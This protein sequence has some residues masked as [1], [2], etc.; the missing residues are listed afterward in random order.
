MNEFLDSL[1]RK[2]LI[3]SFVSW[4][5]NFSPV[6]AFTYAGYDNC[7]EDWGLTVNEFLDP[8]TWFDVLPAA[9]YSW[10]VTFDGSVNQRS[11]PRRNNILCTM[12]E[13]SEQDNSFSFDIDLQK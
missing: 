8:N 5:S 6:D 7:R 12:A 10:D 1:L 2:E 9:S 3:T 11:A 13:N 4:S